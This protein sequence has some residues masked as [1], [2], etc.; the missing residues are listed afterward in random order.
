MTCQ[1]RENGSEAD[2]DVVT[3]FDRHTGE[4]KIFTNDAYVYDREDLNMSIECTSD[5]TGSTV[6]D[7]VVVQIRKPFRTSYREGS[8]AD[9]RR[10]L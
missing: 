10:R 4:F 5:L 6:R 2:F 1:L 9:K 7:N 3:N 8:I